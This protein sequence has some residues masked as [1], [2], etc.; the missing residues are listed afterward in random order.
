M[1]PPQARAIAPFAS[2]GTWGRLN[3][4]VSIQDK[5]TVPYQRAHTHPDSVAELVTQNTLPSKSSNTVHVSGLS[6]VSGSWRTSTN[7][8]PSL[9]R[10]ST[11]SD[12]EPSVKRSRWNRFLPTLGSGTFMKYSGE[13]VPVGSL[14]KYSSGLRSRTSQDSTSAQKLA[15]SRGSVQSITTANMFNVIATP[16]AIYSAPS[17]AYSAHARC[18]LSFLAKVSLLGRPFRVEMVWWSPY[19]RRFSMVLRGRFLAGRWPW[20]RTC[21][22]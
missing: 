3:N 9:M 2:L 22:G 10:R 18:A 5:P 19:R 21:R 13:A 20:S 1:R 17:L 6:R 12:M 15:C 14:T 4:G 8:A 16:D 11:S 7:R